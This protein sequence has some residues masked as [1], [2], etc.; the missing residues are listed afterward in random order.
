MIKSE[1]CRLVSKAHLDVCT[2]KV[3]GGLFGDARSG[4]GYWHAHC[5][6]VLLRDPSGISPLEWMPYL[7]IEIEAC[8]IL[9]LWKSTTDVPTNL[10]S[11][12]SAQF[13]P[14]VV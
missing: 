13:L 9:K 8:L 4:N 11:L 3:V 6:P 1:L 5:C 12:A 2:S 7:S 10:P 14:N